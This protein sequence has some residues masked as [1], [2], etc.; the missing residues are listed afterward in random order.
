ML[1]STILV[2]ECA[3]LAADATIDGAPATVRW[4]P[5]LQVMGLSA[6]STSTADVIRALEASKLD[7]ETLVETSKLVASLC[8]KASARRDVFAKTPGS[9]RALY[10]VSEAVGDLGRRATA[11][12]AASEGYRYVTR[13]RSGEF[14]TCDE[15]FAAALRDL[16]R[17]AEKTD[18]GGHML[19]PLGWV[20]AKGN[21]HVLVASLTRRGDG[22]G[23]SIANLGSETEG[24]GYH[25]VVVDERSGSTK[26]RRVCR[27]TVARHKLSHAATWF[28]LLRSIVL[29]G[30][31]DDGEAAARWYE[32]AVPFLHSD[33]RQSLRDDDVYEGLAVR[34]SPVLEGVKHA[35]GRD[36]TACGLAVKLCGLECMAAQLETFQGEISGRDAHAAQV[37]CRLLAAETADSGHEELARAVKDCCRR[38]D[39]VL[40]KRRLALCGDRHFA[41]GDLGKAPAAAMTKLRDLVQKFMAGDP[42]PSRVEPLTLPVDLGRVAFVGDDPADACVVM[43]RADDVCVAL[44]NQRDRVS[45]T[46]ARRFAVVSS[47][48]LRQLPC[49]RPPDVPAAS[50]FWRQGMRRDTQLDI[51]ALLR[52]LALHIAVSA[53]AL[54]PTRELDGER[55][56]ALAAIAAVADA[57]CRAAAVDEP[58][59]LSLFYSGEGRFAGDTQ[60]PFGFALRLADTSR[61]LLPEPALVAARSAL[62]DYFRTIKRLVPGRNRL[63]QWGDSAK[64]AGPAT[65]SGKPPWVATSLGDARLLD[66]LCVALAY[67]VQPHGANLA[68]Y[69]TGDKPGLIDHLPELGYLRDIVALAKLFASAPS[70]NSPD[71][72]PSVTDAGLKWRLAGAEGGDE[73]VRAQARK[74][75]F[76]S[77]LNAAVTTRIVVT[78]F[79]KDVDFSVPGELVQE[80]DKEDFEKGE[81][82]LGVEATTNAG[83]VLKKLQAAFAG[84]KPRA[85]PSGADAS[86]LCGEVVNGEDDVLHL[87]ALP[88][89]LGATADEVAL[90]AASLAGE[91]PPSWA[92]PPRDVERL[93]C[94]LTVPY[95]RLPLVLRF[96]ADPEKFKA[97]RDVRLRQTLDA[98]LFEPGPWLPADVATSDK[99]LV[100]AIPAPHRDHLKTPAG[101]LANELALA[102]LPTLDAVR[103]LLDL[104]LDLDVGHYSRTRGPLILFAVRLAARVQ[105]FAATLARARVDNTSSNGDDRRGRVRQSTFMAAGSRGFSDAPDD[106]RNICRVAAATLADALIKQAA[107]ALRRWQQRK[108][109]LAIVHAH[110]GYIYARLVF[111]DVATENHYAHEA[112]TA[113]LSAQCYVS[114]HPSDVRHLEI[115]EV[116]LF[117]LWQQRR[118]WLLSILRRGQQGGDGEDRKL[119]DQVL[120]AAVASVTTADDDLALKKKQQDDDAPKAAL[121]REW[122]ESHDYP[123]RF[124]PLGA[125]DDDAATIE[126]AINSTEAADDDYEAWLRARLAQSLRTEVVDVQLGEFV[127]RRT[128][129]EMLPELVR[130]HPDLRA[131]LATAPEDDI[132]DLAAVVGEH[133][134]RTSYRVVSRRLTV[135]VWRDDNGD[136]RLAAA[137]DKAKLRDLDK[138]KLKPSEHWIKD[139]VDPIEHDGHLF[140]A[141]KDLLGDNVLLYEEMP[142]STPKKSGLFGGH[143]HGHEPPTVWREWHLDNK[144]SRVDVFEI[145]EHA[146]EWARVLVYT[147]DKAYTLGVA[148]KSDDEPSQPWLF[149]LEIARVAHRTKGGTTTRQIFV[150]RR[151]LA[152]ALPD[153]LLD[154]YVFWRN[155][156]DLSLVG[157]EIDEG[158]AQATK[159]VV[160][161]DSDGY[162]RRCTLVASVTTES[163]APAD[164]DDNA[165]E[166]DAPKRDNGVV[167]GMFRNL[168]G[169]LRRTTRDVV[170][171]LSLRRPDAVVSLAWPGKVDVAVVGQEELVPLDSSVDSALAT[172]LAR[173]DGLSQALVWKRQHDAAVSAVELPRLKLRFEGPTL[174][175]VEYS[176]FRL[177]GPTIDDMDV[178][179][180]GLALLAAL[181]AALIL[182]NETVAQHKVLTPAPAGG[183][184]AYD[185]DRLAVAL[186][187]PSV[188]AAV[189]LAQLYYKDR[190]YATVAALAHVCVSDETPTPS[191]A[192][193]AA[194][195][196]FKDEGEGV[197]DADAVAC[198][199][200]LVLAATGTGCDGG[201]TPDVLPFSLEH[202]LAGYVALRDSVSAACAL[203]DDEERRALAAVAGEDSGSKKNGKKGDVFS[204]DGAVGRELHNRARA[205]CK[206][207]GRLALPPA[208]SMT[209]PGATGVDLVLAVPDDQ[210]TK[211]KAKIGASY[212]RPVGFEDV[213][214]GDDGQPASKEPPRS[215][216]LSGAKAV[217][218]LRSTFGNK[219]KPPSSTAC[220]PVIYEL[221]TNTL[222]LRIG[223]KDGSFGWGAALLHLAAGPVTDD[224]LLSP[225]RVMADRGGLTHRLLRADQLPRYRPLPKKK[226]FSS[227]M[228][229]KLSGGAG[230][231]KNLQSLWVSAAKAL[232]AAQKRG[233]VAAAKKAAP[234][235]TRVPLTRK[236]LIA[237][238]EHG[239][240]HLVVHNLDGASVPTPQDE[241]ATQQHATLLSLREAA[242][243]LNLV[244]ADATSEAEKNRGG[245]ADQVGLL[246]GGRESAT[247]DKVI[248]S[249]DLVERPLAGLAEAYAPRAAAEISSSVDVTNNMGGDPPFTVRFSAVA[250]E[251]TAASHEKRLRRAAAEDAALRRSQ[252]LP[253]LPVFFEGDQLNF[254]RADATLARLRA[255]LDARCTKDVAAARVA[256]LA[257]G[258]L[259]TVGDLAGWCA[260]YSGR[261]PRVRLGVLLAAAASNQGSEL[262][263]PTSKKPGRGDAA[264]A[265]ALA[266]A[267]ALLEGR[268]DHARRCGH[269]C[270]ALAARL[271]AAGERAADGAAVAAEI[272]LEAEALAEALWERRF[273]FESR[274]VGVYAYDARLLAFEAASGLVLREGQVASVRE[275]RDIA[276]SGASRIKQMIM[277][278]GKTTVLI[279]LLV[280]LLSTPQRLVCA[281]VP[282]SLVV[283]TREVLRR[284]L[285]TAALGH[286]PVRQLLFGRRSPMS[287]ELVMRLESCARRGGVVLA[288]PTSVKAL[289]L[290]SIETLHRLDELLRFTH[291]AVAESK[292][293]QKRSQ[294]KSS[295]AAFFTS[296]KESDRERRAADALG[297][298]AAPPTA[299][300]AVTAVAAGALLGTA[301]KAD[302]L[303]Q[304]A[305]LRGEAQVAASILGLLKGAVAVIDEV[306]IVLHPLKSELN[307]PLGGRAPLDFTV[308]T[309]PLGLR[310]RVPYLLIDAVLSAGS[311]SDELDDVRWR[312]R[313]AKRAA[314]RAAAEIP[315]EDV[316]RLPSPLDEDG[317]GLIDDDHVDDDEDEDDGG[318]SLQE[319]T[320][321]ARGASRADDEGIAARRQLKSARRAVDEA[322][323]RGVADGA[324]QRRP[325]IVLNNEAWYHSTLRPALTAWIIL[326]LRSP[327][328]WAV[329]FAGAGI[330]GDLGGLDDA[331]LRN[332]MLLG[333][334]DSAHQQ[335]SQRL[336]QLC[337]DNQAKLL[338]LYRSWLARVLPFVLSRVDRVNYGLLTAAD[339]ARA[340]TR[341]RERELRGSGGTSKTQQGGPPVRVAAVPRA[342]RLLAVPFT[343]KD[344]PS[345][346]SEFSH[347]DVLIGLSTLAVRHEGL[348]HE[349]VKRVVKDLK[350]AFDNEGAAEPSVERRPSFVRFE[351]YVADAGGVVRGTR[352][353]AN[354]DDDDEERAEIWPLH[355][356]DVADPVMVDPICD[357]LRHSRLAGR[358]YLWRLA[359]PATLELRPAKLAAS[360]QELGGAAIFGSRLGF[361]GTPNDLVPA[362]LSVDYESATD[363]QVARVLSDASVVAV[364]A[365]EAGWTPAGLLRVA[366]AYD[367]LIDA[368]ALVTGVTNREAAVLLLDYLPPGAFDAVLFFDEEDKPLHVTPRST[369]GDE[370]VAADAGVAVDRRFTFYD[371]AHCTGIDVKQ[372]VDATAAVTLSKDTTYRDFAQAAYRLRGL[373]R[374]QRVVVLVVPE[375][376]PL[377][378]EAARESWQRA[379]FG[380]A[381]LTL[382]DVLCWLKTNDIRREKASFFLLATQNVANVVRKVAHARIVDDRADVGA[383]TADKA[384]IQFLRGCLD[385][386]RTRVDYTVENSIPTSQP[387]SQV[388][389][390]MI[391]E[392]A[393]LLSAAPDFATAQKTLLDVS[394]AEEAAAQNRGSAASRAPLGDGQSRE[395]SEFQG[396]Q[397]QEEEEEAEEEAE[398]EHHVQQQAVE[399]AAVEEEERRFDEP[400]RARYSRDDETPE[401]WKLDLLLTAPQLAPPESGART[402]HPFYALADFAV[403]KPAYALHAAGAGGVAA[404]APPRVSFPP[405]IRLSPN[406]H[407]P[408]SHWKRALVQTAPRR[409]KNVAVVLEYTPGADTDSAIDEDVADANDALMRAK[410]SPAEIKAERAA[411]SACAERLKRASEAIAVATAV[412][413]EAR[414]RQTRALASAP[415]QL[416]Q[417]E[418]QPAVLDSGSVTANDDDLPEKLD[419]LRGAQILRAASLRGSRGTEFD[420][421]HPSAGTPSEGLAATFSRRALRP[422]AMAST[423]VVLSLAEAEHLRGALHARRRLATMAG[424]RAEDDDPRLASLA[425]RVVGTWAP[426]PGQQRTPQARDIGDG[427][428]VVLDATPRRVAPPP[429]HDAKVMACLQFFDVADELAPRHAALLLRALQRTPVVERV[430]FRDDVRRC[431]RRPRVAA[432]STAGWLG[433]LIASTAA[434]ASNRAAALRASLAASPADSPRDAS[435]S[436][437]TSAPDDPDAD[438]LTVSDEARDAMLAAINRRRAKESGALSA[439]KPGLRFAHAALVIEDETVIIE[440]RAALVAVRRALKRRHAPATALLRRASRASLAAAEQARASGLVLPS[441]EALFPVG[442]VACALRWLDLNFDSSRPGGGS[443]VYSH[444]AKALDLNKD[445]WIAQDELRTGLHD[446]R[447]YETATDIPPDVS[448]E[449]DDDD[450]A[451]A[452]FLP[453]PR[454]RPVIT[455]VAAPNVDAAA[456]ASVLARASA[457]SA[458]ML[459]DSGTASASSP[460][461]P[462]VVAAGASAS[463]ATKAAHDLHAAV[464]G[465]GK[466]TALTGGAD[467]GGDDVAEAAAKLANEL[468]PDDLKGLVARLRKPDRLEPVWSS[469]GTASGSQ[470]SVWRPEDPKAA[471]RT[472][473]RLCV[474]YYCARGVDDPLAK[475]PDDDPDKADAEPRPGSPP[476][477]G[478]QD[479]RIMCVELS[480][481]YTFRRNR[482]R[483]LAAVAERLCPPPIRFRQVWHLPQ[484]ERSVYGWAPVPKSEAFVALG[485]VATRHPEPPD[486]RCVRT[487]PAAWCR[488]ADAL[489]LVGN[490][491]AWTNSSLGGRKGSLWRQAETGML[492]VARGHGVPSDTPLYRLSMSPLNVADFPAVLLDAPTAP[493]APPSPSANSNSGTSYDPFA[494][495]SRSAAAPVKPTVAKQQTRAPKPAPR[496]GQEGDFFD[497]LPA[498]KPPTS[499]ARK[500]APKQVRQEPAQNSSFDLLGSPTTAPHSIPTG[501][502]PF[503]IFGAGPPVSSSA[504]G[505]ATDPFAGMNFTTPTAQSPT[506]RVSSFPSPSGSEDPFAGLGGGR[507][508]DRQP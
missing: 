117:G 493:P 109:A 32:T 290:K 221:L 136:D 346:A 418:Y 121:R 371:H 112:A 147:N 303:D 14:G 425:L 344:R 458:S 442:A 499:A 293:L 143:G 53:A 376:L 308:Q 15:R 254:Q 270:A 350:K 361:S 108:G 487:V 367:A 323:A 27:L 250:G 248:E 203:T 155:D 321:V 237:L 337:S 60:K 82:G 480:D 154:R 249:S 35:I 410:A 92:L 349:D 312:R 257:L 20:D 340:I 309:A 359:F 461:A 413:D 129:L 423:Y 445:G 479:E 151:F 296:K 239:L 271:W 280:C 297:M 354:D 51:L 260:E 313:V 111:D 447:A 357:L 178:E 495:S 81:D 385:V 294:T 107:P 314:E 443:E 24:G 484:G 198:R 5:W 195:E 459:G 152:G 31:D 138:A 253:R 440:W 299:A 502:D 369:T 305:G 17:D 160:V 76:P 417:Q 288:D 368:G 273:H 146:R 18:N 244:V 222:P 164:K 223:E 363:G 228:A 202:E 335:A 101:A 98:V 26:R 100:D 158:T 7:W 500:P 12:R 38:V 50:C 36:A 387:T 246:L 266:C 470:V 463:R 34:G 140:L 207:G 427:I 41:V 236:D 275:L 67:D 426:T 105:A 326:L 180:D 57:V 99:V 245:L 453:M 437:P 90:E 48:F 307:W 431:R 65:S 428:G 279:P 9:A 122:R 182:Y 374:G 137:V 414:R 177:A 156:D 123:G 144:E 200:K 63:F 91:P 10:E 241:N 183:H 377:I 163:E 477:G 142:S 83:R 206:T 318:S 348:R 85:P 451:Y 157:Y 205:V 281:V 438:D 162:V 93:L 454:V 392:H 336:E 421:L 225:L 234:G 44:E 45:H 125:A 420:A 497:T 217:G 102:P 75:K 483:L 364:D 489:N 386:F 375:L 466:A 80:E 274:G 481:S 395:Q 358:D 333:E 276:L 496:P 370:V 436:T 469:L 188:S 25:P 128:T 430:R 351:R 439:T 127:L 382:H 298:H 485:H 72:A 452:P 8:V 472:A 435:G 300:G 339:I 192:V 405:E 149:S 412:P 173:L 462:V 89:N 54:T 78:I 193:L 332:Y 139:L 68:A 224:I 2:E 478:E 133:K 39:V 474:G 219:R 356:V 468:K 170:S 508:P 331:T 209:T 71:N 269:R 171:R 393:E 211:A 505:A 292:A 218:Y 330:A 328:R 415:G 397:E 174:E 352:A 84:A 59:T 503:D 429:E 446:A 73:R 176:G 231:Q 242:G 324:L 465:D 3:N 383:H 216:G 230:E 185:L 229:D 494:L 30:T 486:L 13:K 124:A 448:V 407:R 19:V 329:T 4:T 444:I 33:P 322:V 28:V 55:A 475:Q 132:R 175:S 456:L 507:S 232:R 261:S 40:A 191:P 403:A 390:A 311:A 247:V 291:D 43:R 210:I 366:A 490:T 301:P 491:P 362:E 252:R 243:A 52:R 103:H 258:R 409:I 172:K 343:S 166:A 265:R 74:A 233:D 96:F 433:G 58:S 201:I 148:E 49:P 424:R 286:R 380:F 106:A 268:A 334:G 227:S 145:V 46:A 189:H 165:H 116:E 338:N 190:Q 212:A 449:V 473:L 400:E 159:T 388:I 471:T 97:L 394:R 467:A 378:A 47:L 406:Y 289:F 77:R 355:V 238:D 66:R 179:G 215:L 29:P 134:H 23:V 325:H 87:R 262:A 1:S 69:L 208:R 398:E 315:V 396:Q 197:A 501:A 353:A 267:V 214:E 120:E 220:W 432:F 186:V 16:A 113:I 204:A 256:R 347:P 342:R 114:A 79:D 118:A 104:A 226:S 70:D 169:A 272:R 492:V 460:G 21:G 302:G 277:G 365:V 317:D 62:L 187:P 434:S 161:V 130:K 167:T 441:A 304:V 506:R 320:L 455:E 341:F 278:A 450:L 119:A 213:P 389:A 141:K 88:G 457:A 408:P 416:H 110:L 282:Q 86:H 199:L 401:P 235:T 391:E 287:P 264:A 285:A 263:A 295:F 94:Y 464:A 306:D 327:T 37:A 184:F 498:P 115:S 196:G 64:S 6:G 419:A 319:A 56:L 399:I 95:L 404:E 283:F 379:S 168:F 42:G 240:V 251:P 476:P 11:L 135:S 194:I 22:F 61:S 153:A 345:D 381:E 504:P 316:L 482:S 310:W 126:A 488:K 373:G 411:A 284:K 150:A 384:K 402:K 372:R 360:G 131:A 255:D 422:R 259:S 181:P